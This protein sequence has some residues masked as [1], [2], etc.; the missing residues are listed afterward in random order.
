MDCEG[1][2]FAR[3]HYKL[4]NRLRMCELCCSRHK[5]SRS[6]TRLRASETYLVRKL[7]QTES[8]PLSENVYGPQNV[9]WKPYNG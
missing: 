2:T 6:D 1:T 7:G 4:T 5:Q 3:P 8:L 9:E